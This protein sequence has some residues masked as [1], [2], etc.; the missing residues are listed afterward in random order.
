M[1][2]TLSQVVYRTLL[3]YSPSTGGLAAPD[4]T[5]SA[6]VVRNGTTDGAVTVTVTSVSTGR[7]K[8]SFAIPGTYTVDDV[9]ELV[10]T[11]AI[12]S[13]PGG[14]LWSMQ[15]D[16]TVNSRSSHSA[17]DVWAVGTRTLTSF[18]TLVADIWSAATSGLTTASSIG[19]LIV[20]NLN[21]TITSRMA[22]FT[23][24]A[25]DNTGIGQIK[26]KTDSLPA[27]PAAVSDI[28]TVSAISTHVERAGGPLALT[29]ASA[30]SADGK[31]TTS[32]TNM[33]TRFLTM[34]ESYSG[35]T[36]YRFITG[37]LSQAPTGSGG[38]GSAGTQ[39]IAL[40]LRIVIPGAGLASKP[41]AQRLRLNRGHVGTVRLDLMDDDGVPV[42]TTSTTLTAALVTSPGRAPLLD[43]TDPT[44]VFG[45]EGQIEVAF[46]MGAAELVGKSQ[47]ILIVTR[48]NGDS[49]ITTAELLV[50]IKG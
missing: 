21:A 8:L 27:S 50:E 46:N 13:V 29:Q 15:V 49:D 32:F 43:L 14:A 6:S 41:G 9:L 10:A 20:D 44:E 1:R 7:Y 45:D 33:V 36:L 23:Y 30:A 5:P 3:I 38:G 34:I 11:W 37:A 40:P 4:A 48:D 28:P 16:S 2:V 17:D 22:T 42:S 47:V 35:G 31:L 39:L 25:P 12:S 24:T 26:A 18:G 19:K